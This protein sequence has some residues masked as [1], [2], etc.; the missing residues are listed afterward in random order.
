M[1]YRR[2]KQREM[3]RTL[4]YNNRFANITLSQILDDTQE[5][6]TNGSNLDNLTLLYV[7]ASLNAKPSFSQVDTS[8]NLKSNLIYVDASL[9]LKANLESPTFTGT[10]NAPT[11]ASD[12][13]SDQLATT[14]FVSTA[15][16][17]LVSSA[18]DTL[19]TLNELAT[20]LGDDANFST[21]IITSLG[22]KAPSNNPNFTGTLN[23]SKM[24]ITSDASFSG[25]VDICGNIFALTAIAGTNT[26]QLATTQFVTTAVSTKATITDVDTSLNEKANLSYVDP[27]LNAKASLIYVDAS[28]NAKAN[29]SYVDLSL[30]AKAN[31]SYVD[32]SLN[33]KANYSYVD[34]SLNAK[35]NYSYV[36]P[37]L[38]AKA[39][40]I[41]VDASLN[42]KANLSYVDLSLNA[43]A[44]LVSPNFSGTV[45]GIT[46]SMVGLSNVDNTADL[47]KVVSTATQNALNAKANLVSPIFSGTPQAP[48]AAN[49]TNTVQIATTA[50]V[51][52]LL[53]AGTIIQSAAN[54]VP[55]G[56]LICNGQSLST[57]T[58]AVLFAAIAYTYGGNGSTFN[59]PNMQG[60]VGIGAGTGTGL[61]TRNLGAIG[62]AETHTLTVNE[63]PS[64]N[65]GGLT[66]DA[67]I[68]LRF[69]QG[70]GSALTYSSSGTAGTDI[71]NHTIASQGG[72]APHNIMQPYVVLQYLIKY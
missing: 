67:T 6:Q 18:P 51:H 26:T 10:P 42:A 25:N 62:G 68:N 36:D 33:A 60:R 41:Y 70:G 30:N 72:N 15:V 9:I 52:S 31:L 47:N 37:S 27:S 54:V 43:K 32:L 13:N 48:T 12:N 40:L 39:S 38:N 8:L 11:A 71:H 53:P 69:C 66:G 5:N 21:T 49:T 7:D 63:M 64:H 59:V 4:M 29:Y 23:A 1:S 24:L 58:Y 34:P 20:A 35:A 46:K 22:S 65:H 57:S 17:N 44:N 50:F 3:S 28:L 19:N 2:A 56:W 45:V 55:F 14:A 61:T 16:A